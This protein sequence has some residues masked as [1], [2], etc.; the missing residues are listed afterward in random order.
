MGFQAPTPDETEHMVRSGRQ[1]RQWDAEG[2]RERRTRVTSGS[3][4]VIIAC[5]RTPTAAQAG[6]TGKT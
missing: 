1:R 4:E 2:M 5:G 3:R 6:E